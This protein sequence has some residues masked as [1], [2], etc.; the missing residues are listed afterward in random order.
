MLDGALADR[1]VAD[2][3]CI[4]ELG[5]QS[6]QAGSCKAHGFAVFAKI[7][8]VRSRH[9]TIK[10]VA[11]APLGVSRPLYGCVMCVFVHSKWAADMQPMPP[12]VRQLW[13]SL[14]VLQ[15]VPDP[16]QKMHLAT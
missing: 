1:R 4:G 10:D 15:S 5:A 3:V 6:G 7:V 9:V 12:Q 11:E 2:R 8:W 14:T 13:S 16:M